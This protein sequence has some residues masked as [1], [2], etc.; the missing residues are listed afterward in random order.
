MK[1]ATVG[2]LGLFVLANIIALGAGRLNRPAPQPAG[3][4]VFDEAI[5]RPIT[6]VN[7]ID[8]EFD[9]SIPRAVTV[10]NN[11][12]P[13]PDESISRAATVC[14]SSTFVDCNANCYPDDV[15]IASGTS[16][17][18]QPNDIP[19][20]C[21]TDCQSNGVPDDCDLLAG[22]SDDCDGDSIPDECLPCTHDCV[23]LDSAVCTFDSCVDGVCQTRLIAYGDVNN[24]SVPDLDDILC[25]IA[26]FGDFLICPNGDLAPACTGDGLIDLD[27]ILAVIDAFGGGDPCC[28]G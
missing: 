14:Q 2:V 5:S 7:S 10:L 16:A 22:T 17:D 1:L 21:E 23:C 3:T 27:D 12:D 20:E 6:V 4:I 13:V 11:I 9:E 28:G 15:D 8:P 18:C 24:S 26:G 25:V 19:D